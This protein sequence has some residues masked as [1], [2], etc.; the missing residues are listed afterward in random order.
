MVKKE[1]P[2]FIPLYEIIEDVVFSWAI[3]YSVVDLEHPQSVYELTEK[4]TSLMEEFKVKNHE[5]CFKNIL[6]KWSLFNKKIE[7]EPINLKKIKSINYL[8]QL[9]QKAFELE[10]M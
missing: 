6:I 5:E 7:Q 9:L 10:V 3:K 8:E 4:M 2:N 1:F